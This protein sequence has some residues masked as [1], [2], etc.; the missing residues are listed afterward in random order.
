MRLAKGMKR[1]QPV[2]NAKNGG[3]LRTHALIGSF[4]ELP[5]AGRPFPLHQRAVVQDEWCAVETDNEAGI[6]I[7]GIPA[8]NLPVGPLGDWHGYMWRPEIGTNDSTRTPANE[9]ACRIG[10]SL[11]GCEALVDARKALATIGHP[12]ARSAHPVWAAT[13]P[14]AVAEMVMHSLYEQGDIYAT[15]LHETRRWLDSEGR[16]ACALMLERAAPT[17]DATPRA[18]LNAWTKELI[19]RRGLNCDGTRA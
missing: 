14:R 15:D 13:H 2:M 1:E 18:R 10:M 6:Y 19:T 7:T 12:A 16:R 8:L 11:W 5:G 3:S 9:A 4:S 17:L